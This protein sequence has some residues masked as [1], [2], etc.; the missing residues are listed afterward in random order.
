MTIAG[1]KVSEPF[2]VKLQPCGTAS[3]R[4]VD[5]AGEPIDG[6]GVQVGG[7]TSVQVGG[8]SQSVKTDKKGRFRFEGLVAGY[9]YSMMVE[10]VFGRIVATA[11]VE[12]GKNK[13]LGDIKVNDN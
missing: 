5:K 13:D 12:P 9:P 8:G 7:V 10:N 3:G 11:V 4:L 1:G 2:I 6:R